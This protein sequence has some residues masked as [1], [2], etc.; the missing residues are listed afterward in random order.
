VGVLLDL[1]FPQLQQ[2]FPG[3]GLVIVE[4]EFPYLRFPWIHKD[5]GDIEIHEHAEEFVVIYGNFTHVHYG[6]G[7]YFAPDQWER[8]AIDQLISDL[9]MLFGDRLK[10]HR[11]HTGGGGIIREGDENYCPRQPGD[12]PEYVW[13]GP[14]NDAA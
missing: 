2:R 10:M 3:R 1:L 9:D 14:L 11:S 13:S 12:P 8:K 5:V 7:E 4:G 6:H